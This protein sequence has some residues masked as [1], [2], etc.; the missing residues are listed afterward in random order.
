MEQSNI[1][2][3]RQLGHYRA[4]LLHKTHLSSNKVQ[5][6][7]NPSIIGNFSSMRTNAF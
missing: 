4:S 5:M 3:V 6:S 2:T 1:L 7:D